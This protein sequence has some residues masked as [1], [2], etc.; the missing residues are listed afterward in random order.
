M[1]CRADPFMWRPSRSARFP[2]FLH[3]PPARGA[4]PLPP[5]DERRARRRGALPGQARLSADRALRAHGRGPG[6]FRGRR[7]VGAARAERLPAPA[8]GARARRGQRRRPAGA[9]VAPARRPPWRGARRRRVPRGAGARDHASPARAGVPGAA[10]V[11]RHRRGLPARDPPAAGLDRRAARERRRAAPAGAA[12]ACRRPGRQGGGAHASCSRSTG[13][14]A[15]S[16]SAGRP[17]G[18]C[19]TARAA[20]PSCTPRCSTAQT[21]RL[22]P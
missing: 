19:P 11:H 21:S 5:G 4:L 13:R 17:S 8:L 22:A 3:N 15:R 2:V 10:N 12:P 18:S 6:A 9:V 20:G 1:W 14:T 7:L 16:C